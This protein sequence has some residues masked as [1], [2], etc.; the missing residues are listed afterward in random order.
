MDL[1]FL[2]K[3]GI[4]KPW[5]LYAI[6]AIVVALIIMYFAYS[7]RSCSTSTEGFADNTDKREKTAE[8]MFFYVD[9][10]P[11]CKTAKP[12]WESLKSTYE[13]AKIKDRRIIFTEVNCTN[14]T[15]EI[16]ALM[17]KYKIEGYPT[18]KLIK[19]NQVYD[20]DAKPSEESLVSFMNQFL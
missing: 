11:H 6:L 13:T 3:F 8:L 7:S 9:W 12:V 19:D 14:E 17:D 16:E 15:K 10:C 4:D 1:S 18:F 20:F 5:V 2:K